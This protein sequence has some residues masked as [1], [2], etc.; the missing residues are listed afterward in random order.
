[1]DEARRRGELRCDALHAVTALLGDVEEPALGLGLEHRGGEELI[2]V[3]VRTHRVRLR[4]RGLPLLR[5]AA[6]RVVARDE[7]AG[8]AVKDGDGEGLRVRAAARGA[9]VLDRAERLGASWLVLPG[10]A[11]IVQRLRVWWERKEIADDWAAGTEES[12]GVNYM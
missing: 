1:M 2:A 11:G 5:E 8:V 6:A 7:A 4:F 3:G 10:Y 9:I 12:P